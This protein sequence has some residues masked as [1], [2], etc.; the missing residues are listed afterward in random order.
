MKAKAFAKI[1]TFLAVGDRREDGYHFID[2]VMRTVSVYDTVKISRSKKGIVLRCNAKIP[3]KQNLAYKAAQAFFDYT[4]IKGNVRIDLKKRIPSKAGLGGGSSNAAAVLTL[5]NKRYGTKLSKETLAE[6]SLPL[7]ADVPFFICGGGARCRG[8][9][10][11][12]SPVKH[13]PLHLVLVK[14]AADCPTGKMYALLD[15]KKH[16]SKAYSE[17]FLY[18]SFEEVCPSECTEVINCLKSMGAEKA[19]LSG[20]GSCVFGV[21]KTK[22]QALAAE[23]Q[24]KKRY[25]FVRYAKTV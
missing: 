2:T 19:L 22:N 18:N 3:P 11:K 16:I 21:F 1:N 14:P 9:G 10:E 6:I 15:E 8:I 13:L 17:D 24:L 23:K 7:G 5:L 20:S 4:G 12:L 25:P